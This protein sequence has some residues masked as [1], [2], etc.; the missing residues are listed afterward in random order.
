MDNIWE[1]AISILAGNLNFGRSYLIT[2]VKPTFFY[3][4]P[5]SFSSRNY[6]SY[7]NYHLMANIWEI[8]IQTLVILL[9]LY[10]QEILTKC[11]AIYLCI[12]HINR[13][14]KAIRSIL[15][16]ELNIVEYFKNS[17][18]SHWNSIKLVIHSEFLQKF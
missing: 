6:W 14:L 2:T 5:L 7:L 1:K 4:L 17:R 11:Y 12:M 3:V 18:N 9:Q 10:K 15:Q 13:I 8:Y 16:L